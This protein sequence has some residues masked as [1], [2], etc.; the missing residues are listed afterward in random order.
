MKYLLVELIHCYHPFWG[1][2]DSDKITPALSFNLVTF[3][4]ICLEHKDTESKV[5]VVCETETWLV[6]TYTT[7]PYPFSQ[8]VGFHICMPGD[9]APVIVPC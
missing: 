1:I 3:A 8:I 5:I 6:V 9:E 7:Q 2:V 4:C